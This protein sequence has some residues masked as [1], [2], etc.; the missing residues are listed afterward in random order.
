M[1]SKKTAEKKGLKIGVFMALALAMIVLSSA[2]VTAI[3][4]TPGRVTLTFEP[5]LEQTTSVTIVNTEHKAMEISLSVEDDSANIVILNRTSLV[6]KAGEEQKT[7]TYKIKLPSSESEIGASG[8]KARI[9][10][11]EI[12]KNNNSGASIGVNIAVEQQIY[13]VTGILP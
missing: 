6:F 10:A 7:L 2:N 5:S 4:I 9:R 1:N 13:V 3:G 11:V 12:A 8:I